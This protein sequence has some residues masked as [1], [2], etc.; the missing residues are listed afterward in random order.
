V[1]TLMKVKESGCCESQILRRL[2]IIKNGFESKYTA[3]STLLC[4]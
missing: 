4:C 1:Y 3:M 2:A